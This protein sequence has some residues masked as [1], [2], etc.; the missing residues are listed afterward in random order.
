MII[1]SDVTISQRRF[2]VKEVQK[3][4]RVESQGVWGI[5]EGQVIGAGSLRFLDSMC[6]DVPQEGQDTVKKWE[7]EGGVC[8]VVYMTVEDDLAMILRLEDEL[9]E[10]ALRAVQSLEA[11]SVYVAM[12]TGDERRAAEAVAQSLG[13]QERHS[14]KTPLQKELWVKGAHEDL[15][16][17]L[18][19]PLLK[20]PPVTC[21]LGDGL[22]DGPALAAADLG[23]AIASGLQLPCDAADVVIGSG[24]AMLSRFVQALHFAKRCKDLIRQNLA[25]ATRHDLNRS[26]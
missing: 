8:T 5:I 13:I 26:E 22:N 19:T 15:E 12:L 17:P 10:D 2:L 6:I 11:L 16:D 25:F 7:E 24:G 23:V 21:M 9:R 3:F 20:K 1:S 18:S 4:T 14:K